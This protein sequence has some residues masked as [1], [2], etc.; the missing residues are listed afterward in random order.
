MSAV[1]LYYIIGIAL[2]KLADID[3]M[4]PC[5]WT[6]LFDIHCP[7]C[8]LTRAFM[9]L[10]VFDF[11]AAF[12]FNPLIFII[13]PAGVYYFFTDIKKFKINYTRVP[14]RDAIPES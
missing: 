7:G 11:E 2:Y 6:W 12:N 9:K 13:A 14:H 4:L 10:I 5:I 1:A 8:G 3:I